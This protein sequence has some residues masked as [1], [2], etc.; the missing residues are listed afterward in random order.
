MKMPRWLPGARVVCIG[1]GVIGLEI[2]ASAASRGCRV[3]VLELAPGPMGRSRSSSYQRNRFV[4]A[5]YQVSPMTK[6]GVPSALCFR[7]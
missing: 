7:D 4:A 5:E 1:A 2:A 6:K 3:T